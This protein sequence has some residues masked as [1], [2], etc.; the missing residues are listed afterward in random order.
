[1]QVRAERF[2][3]GQHTH[4]GV[5]DLVGINRTQ[6]HAWHWLALLNRFQQPGQVHARVE[7]LS[8]P[9]QVDAG[10]HDLLKALVSQAI[11]LLE[12]NARRHAAALAAR[13]RHD[14][15]RAE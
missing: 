8:V 10:K 11:E 13:H 15:E 4:E 7:V 14:T 6:A 3:L 2:C 12:H 1:M 9:A 5:A